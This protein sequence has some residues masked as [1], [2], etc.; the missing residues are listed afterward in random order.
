MT[1]AIRLISLQYFAD[2]FLGRGDAR[3]MR[4]RFDASVL[5]DVHHCFKRHLTGRAT[6]AK[7]HRTEARLQASQFIHRVTQVRGGLLGFRRKEFK[8]EMTGMTFL[9]VHECNTLV[10]LDQFPCFLEGITEV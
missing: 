4:G 5:L 6:R 1:N 10:E 7:R 2:I 8:A 3:N 9:R